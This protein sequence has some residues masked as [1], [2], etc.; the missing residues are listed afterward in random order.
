MGINILLVDDHPVFRKGLLFL[1]AEEEDM[2]VVGEAGDGETAIDRVRELVPDV[3]IMD[4]TMPNL[5]GIEATRQII[6]EFPDT[7]VIAL[8]IHSG[9]RF[10]EDMLQ[11]GAVGY[12]L[13]ESVPEE[14]IQAIRIA[15]YGEMYL[16]SAI[17]SV[18]V[19]G[20]KEVL[21]HKGIKDTGPILRT[22]LYRPPITDDI[23]LRSRLINRLE[24]NRKKPFTLVSAPAGYGKSVLISSW[25]EEVKCLHAWLSLDEEH[26]DSRTF[27][28]YFAAAVN[29]VF[30]EELQT[31]KSYLQTPELP[32]LS[33]ISKNMINEL[34]QINDD[35]V[36]VL[37]DFHLISNENVIELINN[38][39]QY[40]PLNMHLAIL[41]R[42]D[43]PLSLGELRDYSRMD[44]IRMADLSFTSN[45]IRLLFKKLHEIE[46]R[47]TV[48]EQLLETT[49][50]WV[51]GLRLFSLGI[52]EQEDEER[53]L[54]QMK[55]VSPL[56]TE[57]LL[58][59]MLKNQPA[60][61]QNYLLKTSIL[62]RFCS[63]LVEA[64]DDSETETNEHKING[65]EFIKW[66][67]D[68]NLFVIPLDNRQNWFRYHHLFQQLLQQKLKQTCRSEEIAALHSRACEWFE[69]EGLVDEAIQQAFAIDEIQRAAQI[70]ERNWRT[71]MNM[72]KWHVVADWMSKLPDLVIQ[73]SL[74]LLLVQAWKSFY[75]LDVATMSQ[76]LERIE[77]FTENYAVTPD[78]SG[79]IAMFQGYCAYFS[80]EG[81]R[82]LRHIEYAL[83]H[84]AKANIEA[85]SQTEIL[86]GIGAHMEGQLE[87]VI[88]KV[89]AWLEETALLNP[90]REACLLWTLAFTQYMDGDLLAAARHIPRLGEISESH[91]IENFK[92]WRYYLDGLVHLHQ[93]DL[94]TA[95]RCLEEAGKSKYSHFTR[96]AVDALVSLTLAYQANGQS[97]H[98]AA[99][100][101]SLYRFADYLGT[102]FP[103]IAESCAV[104]LSIIQGRREPAVRWLK[105][106]APPTA[107]VMAWWLEVPCVSHC[108]ALI[109]EGSAASLSKAE[110]QLRLYTEMNKAQY[111]TVQLIGI[112]NLLAMACE[113]Q[114]K[115][116]E[117]RSTLE[118]S[119]TL[120]RPSGFIFPFLELGPPMARMLKRLQKQNVTD[121]FIKN[122]LSAF[123]RLPLTPSPRPL[124]PPSPGLRS[125][126]PLVEPLTNRELDI[127]ELLGKRLQNKE[128]AEQLYISPETVKA[129]LKNIFQ[130]LDASGRR[131][132]VEKAKALGI[133]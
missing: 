20:Y 50:G 65:R 124:V 26:N 119:L 66:L 49:E 55:G 2:M 12:L 127:L 21:N 129:H 87:R 73:D 1:L 24:K 46:L 31:I 8:S 36:M 81:S 29:Q 60:E 40:P 58:E 128:I 68:A 4:I 25:L 126:Q 9:K 125:P 70:I 108:R 42:R 93:G 17:T 56:L 53:I 101:Q 107:E 97:D 103:V 88:R 79:E 35:F 11:A 76:V 57:S 114:S 96:A 86:F 61:I 13:K 122:L 75:Y 83:E 115:H 111:N 132:A 109:A 38:L 51:V 102:P 30:P 54:A 131:N 117:A 95:I 22:K 105:T 41:T 23:V 89:T 78:L 52:K 10:A 82:S 69:T 106:N 48:S 33:I 116:D 80:N 104:R 77:N 72:G 32:P 28:A 62:N 130:K 47:D 44:E 59:Q 120:A 14:L 64:L 113:K 19:K 85:R 123:S 45:E 92:A 74:Q 91:S 43:P 16:S 3:V 37:D 34:D 71:M 94:E 90:L 27:L 133:L 18:V 15:M 63:E 112:L 84:I 110:E 100:L 98:A 5:D 99:T 118:Q 6:S 67:L 7:K 121:G 39:I